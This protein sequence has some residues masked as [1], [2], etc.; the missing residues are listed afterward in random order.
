[1]SQTS[2]GLQA[3]D[4]GTRAVSMPETIYAPHPFDLELSCVE[5][6]EYARDW[7]KDKFSTTMYQSH[8]FHTEVGYARPTWSGCTKE[9]AK[10][11]QV[12]HD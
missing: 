10:I 2:W 5:A 3:F 4:M 1:M 6:D 11:V 9:L 7:M 12:M 8:W